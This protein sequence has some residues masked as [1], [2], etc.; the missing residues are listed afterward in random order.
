VEGSVKERLTGALIFVAAAVIIVPE[1]FSGPEPQTPDAAQVP[2]QSADGPPL[3]TYS[4]KLDDADPPQIET[5]APPQPQE[6]AQAMAADPPAE[7]P[8]PAQPAAQVAAQSAAQESPAPAVKAAAAAGSWWVQVGLFSSRENA[9]R[10]TQKLRSANIDVV[11]DKYISNGKELLRV[12]AGPVRDRA[13][14]QALVER[15]KATGSDA[16]VAPP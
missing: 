3:R 9:E 8:A 14:A 10:Q 7:S 6:P 1:M 12:R 2:E 11:V 4:M 5:P 13:E 16:R 15:V